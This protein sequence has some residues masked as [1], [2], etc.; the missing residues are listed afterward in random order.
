M[1]LKRLGL[2]IRFDFLSP[3]S[4]EEHARQAFEEIF[5]VLTVSEL[6]GLLIYGGQDPLTDPAENI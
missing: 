3:A 1:Q 2:G 6:D 5:S 4:E